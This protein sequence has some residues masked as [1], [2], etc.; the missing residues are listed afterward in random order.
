MWCVPLTWGSRLERVTRIE[1]ALSAWESDL[2][3]LARVLTWRFDCPQV[4]AGVQ[5]PPWLMAR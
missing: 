1:L 3:P 2:S 4:T 5:Q